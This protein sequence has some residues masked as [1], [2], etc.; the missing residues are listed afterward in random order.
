MVGEGKRGEGAGGMRDLLVS[1]PLSLTPDIA[2]LL[3]PGHWFSGSPAGV[4]DIFAIG[5]E[6]WASSQTHPSHPFRS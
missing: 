4:L 1:P 2:W 3:L 6:Q 5:I